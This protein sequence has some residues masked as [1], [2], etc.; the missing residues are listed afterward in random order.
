M[1]CKVTKIS[2]NKL[3]YSHYFWGLKLAILELHG[4]YIEKTT[5]RVGENIF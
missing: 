1:I 2:N 4:L 3:D 5:H